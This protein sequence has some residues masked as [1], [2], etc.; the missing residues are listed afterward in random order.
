M[1]TLPA[2]ELIVKLLPVVLINGLGA[3]DGSNTIASNVPLMLNLFVGVAIPNRQ[4]HL[5][6]P[7]NSSL[8]ILD[9]F[10]MLNN[11]PFLISLVLGTTTNAILPSVSFL[12]KEM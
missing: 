10:M 3:E 8:L 2:A 11:V 12:C 7:I 5:I 9:C 4:N 6:L 1:M